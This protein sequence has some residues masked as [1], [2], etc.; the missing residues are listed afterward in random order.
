MEILPEM[1]V[2]T[3]LEH[4]PEL[5]NAL[6][7]MAPEF[8][9]LKNPFLRKT[10]AK[11]TSLKQA[12]AVA[13]IQADTLV[14]ALRHKAGQPAFEG[15][16][17]SAQEFEGS[18]PVWLTSSKPVETFDATELIDS[19]AMPLGQIM[20][21]IERLKPGEHYLLITPLLPVPLLEKARNKGYFTWTEKVSDRQFQTWIGK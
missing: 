12:A 9:K 21:D 4:F 19:G 3:L 13:G 15:Y 16:S 6:V 7:E 2:A 18:R 14:N 5:E 20:D 17:G 10:I 8:K 1:K 11:V